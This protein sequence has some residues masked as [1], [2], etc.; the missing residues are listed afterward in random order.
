MAGAL[1]SPACDVDE[2]G[3]LMVGGLHRPARTNRSRTEQSARKRLESLPLLRDCAWRDVPHPDAAPTMLSNTMWQA[4]RPP[5]RRWRLP[6]SGDPV[7]YKSTTL[8]GD[9]E[10]RQAQ[11]AKPIRGWDAPSVVRRVS[12]AQRILPGDGCV[13]GEGWERR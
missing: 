6:A 12:R 7:R 5:R 13:P 10:E 1:P 2:H 11:K 3:R 8:Y 4:T 9:R